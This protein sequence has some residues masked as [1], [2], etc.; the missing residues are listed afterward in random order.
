[1]KY[2]RFLLGSLFLKLSRVV[3]KGCKKLRSVLGRV[4]KAL[5]KL[6]GPKTVMVVSDAGGALGHLIGR[7]IMGYEICVYCQR[8]RFLTQYDSRIVPKR[9]H[10]IYR[11]FSTVSSDAPMAVRRACEL[12]MS[13]PPFYPGNVDDEAQAKAA[14][15]AY[16]DILAERVKQFKAR[17]EVA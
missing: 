11:V 10:R 9:Q 5:E 15:D 7:N 13:F 16:L 12:E 17:L 2:L 3:G 14:I 1:M 4:L 8:T 6:K